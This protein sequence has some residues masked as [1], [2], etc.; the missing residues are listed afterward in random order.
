MGT[1]NPKKKIAFRVMKSENCQ[2]SLVFQNQGIL[3]PTH[4]I[5]TIPFSS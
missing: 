1:L 2:L 3:K 5:E 4:H